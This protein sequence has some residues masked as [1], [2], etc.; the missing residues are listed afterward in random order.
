VAGSDLSF[1]PPPMEKLPLDEDVPFHEPL[2]ISMTTKHEK[3]RREKNQLK[4][5][6]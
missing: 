3:K 5:L 2:S 1:P 6:V 4:M